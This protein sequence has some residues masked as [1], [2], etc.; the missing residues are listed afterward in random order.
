MQMYINFKY[1]PTNRRDVSGNVSTVIKQQ[2]R[3]EDAEHQEAGLGTERVFD[4]HG[5]EQ[6]QEECEIDEC[7]TASQTC[8]WI[9]EQETEI[10]HRNDAGGEPKGE[11]LV[12][13]ATI[14]SFVGDR[15]VLKLQLSVQSCALLSDA[16]SEQP[17]LSDNLPRGAP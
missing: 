7:D 1:T 12:V 14:L 6:Q 16:H 17:V 11:D 10:K 13:A 5:E 2:Q 3:H 8:E 9:D 4:Q 15:G